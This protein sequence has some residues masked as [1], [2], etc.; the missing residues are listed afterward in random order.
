MT[1]L[2]CRRVG[3]EA[4]EPLHEILRLCGVEM[5]KRLGLDHWFPPIPLERMRR[6]AAESRVHAVEADGQLVATF[7]TSTDSAKYPEHFWVDPS[8]RALYLSRLAVLPSHQGLGIGKWCL[9][10]TERQARELNCQAIRFDSHANN[11][12]LV[13]Y[14]LHHGYTIRGEMPWIASPERS[15][16][17]TIYEKV[18]D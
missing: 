8:H 16:V 17:I 11:K 14:Y 4:V 5:H 9:R 2:T 3:P 12:P 10:E 6:E 7:T 13:E 18:L 15:W 1:T